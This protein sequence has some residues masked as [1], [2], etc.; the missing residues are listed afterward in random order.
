MAT[1]LSG[2]LPSPSPDPISPTLPLSPT[3]STSACTSRSIGHSKSWDY[4]GTQGKSICQIGK[5]G[6]DEEK[7]GHHVAGQ[8]P[9]QHLKKS[10]A[11]EYKEMKEK[12]VENEK[13]KLEKQQRVS[14]PGSFMPEKAALCED[15]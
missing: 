9:T 5:G 10:H 7:C 8:F 13:R 2:L 11:K 3:L 6:S 1:C 4:D 12:E 14:T 15:K